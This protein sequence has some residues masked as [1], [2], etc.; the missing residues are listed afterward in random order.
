L[1]HRSF[2]TPYE[3]PILFVD[4]VKHAFRFRIFHSPARQGLKNQGKLAL[5]T[6]SL[7]FRAFRFGLPNASERDI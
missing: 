5:G 1:N 3:T 6:L 4:Q 2:D 7:S